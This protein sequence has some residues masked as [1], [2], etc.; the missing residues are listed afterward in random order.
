[1]ALRGLRGPVSPRTCDVIVRSPAGVENLLTRLIIFCQRY[2]KGPQIAE[3]WS[4]WVPTPVEKRMLRKYGSIMQRGLGWLFSV[5]YL[6]VYYYPFTIRFYKNV[7]ILYIALL[8]IA[9]LYNI[10]SFS[11]QLIWCVVMQHAHG[12]IFSKSY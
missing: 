12:E 6:F 4:A 8:I 5:F 11:T 10:S 2:A 3:Y 1:M 9:C 7:T